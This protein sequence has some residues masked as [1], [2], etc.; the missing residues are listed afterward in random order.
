MR[1]QRLEGES[2]TSAGN[3]LI[4]QGLLAERREF[5]DLALALYRQAGEKMPKNDGVWRL[6]GD[7]ETRAGRLT[8]A[9][10]AFEQALKLKPSPVDRPEILRKL[11]RVRERNLDQDGALSAWR[12]LADEYP[13][14]IHLIEEVSAF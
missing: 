14:V 10:D 9:S 2:R 5:Y 3:Y 11:A 1:W 12:Q 6:V 7:L 8:E 4:L 13:D